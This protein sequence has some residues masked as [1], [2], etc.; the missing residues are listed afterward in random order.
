MKSGDG[1]RSFYWIER[2][3]DSDHSKRAMRRTIGSWVTE[4]FDVPYVREM[5][6]GF[7]IRQAL[8][9]RP[10]KVRC[11]KREELLVDDGDPD[12]FTR[13]IVRSRH[14]HTTVRFDNSH[15]LF[16]NSQEAWRA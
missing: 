6:V 8:I 16:R 13:K 2:A 15:Y 9:A 1:L 3:Q 4:R 10:E 14:D 7:G 5:G 12:S 11:S